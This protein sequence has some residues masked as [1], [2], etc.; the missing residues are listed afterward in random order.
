MRVYFLYT[1]ILALTAYSFRD[2]FA[3]AC[4]LVFLGML[5]EHPDFPRS[6]ADV[7][8]WNP[9]NM[10]FVAVVGL[11]F[12]QRRRERLTFDMSR[13][14]ST[15]AFGYCAVTVVSSA[16]AVLDAPTWYPRN[17]ILNLYVLY[18]LKIMVLSFLIYDGARTRKRQ[19]AVLLCVMSSAVVISILVVKYRWTQGLSEDFMR[20]RQRLGKEVG[21]HPN[22]F[23]WVLAGAFWGICAMIPLWKRRWV[24][25]LNAGL[26]AL[27]ALAVA[28]TQS[29]AGYLAIIS[30]GL[31]LGVVRWRKV[32]L[33]LP[34]GVAVVVVVMPTTAARM[35]MGIGQSDTGIGEPE[36]DMDT[37][38]AGRTTDI[39]PHVI[40]QIA[41]S[42]ILGHGR[43]GILRT[44]ARDKIA[45][46]MGHCP[47]HPHNAYL[48]LMIDSGLIGT[49]LVLLFF[50]GCFRVCVRL[51]RVRGVP[52]ASA[53]GAMALAQLVA[54]LVSGLSG[55]SLFP[56]QSMFLLLAA[57]AVAMRMAVQWRL[58]GP[59]R[60]RRLPRPRRP[61]HPTTN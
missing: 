19:L 7:A 33:L 35:M 6:I 17:L 31:L 39:W 59:A 34:I 43:L 61:V 13:T 57:L 42:P 44:P 30:V 25:V 4:G 46:S 2:W 26:A 50:G 1:V 14:A 52:L 40:E 11:W 9:W 29:R 20:G 54:R 38:T 18:P 45:V 48:E 3:G 5:T 41:N 28:L 23:G 60:T 16:V 24:R 22:Q 47:S 37:I 15:L 10:L 36:H 21:M 32:L 8:G 27:P 12:V 55:R 56:I 58:I 49:T 51:F 53:V